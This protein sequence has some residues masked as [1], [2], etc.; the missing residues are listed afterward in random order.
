MPPA[1]TAPVSPEAVT[2]HLAMAV[3][4]EGLAHLF[5]LLG[6]GGRFTY[7]HR[8]NDPEAVLPGYNMLR[9]CGTLWFMLTAVRALR[10]PL[11]DTEARALSAGLSYAGKRMARPDWAPG[12]ALVTKGEVKLG[13]VGLALLALSD[14]RQ[15]PDLLPKPR[16]PAPE[17]AQLQG[18]VFGQCPADLRQ[19]RRRQE[20]AGMA[21]VQ[22]QKPRQS[23]G[24]AG[25]R[26]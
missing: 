26:G 18:Q 22:P 3:A 2:P 6:P 20:P 4:A 10:L 19:I 23:L 8:E 11:L 25:D 21:L 24:P 15:M 5:R 12:L 13:G 14:Y 7:A 17:P 9:H 1:L 16:L